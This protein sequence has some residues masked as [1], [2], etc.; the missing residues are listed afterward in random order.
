MR[1]MA[2]VIP[3]FGDA[4]QTTVL[5]EGCGFRHADVL[6][7]KEGPPTRHRLF[8]RGSSDLTARVVRSSSCTV[9][10]PE[11][12]AEMEPGMRSEAFISTAEG[13]LHRFR[14]ILGFLS[15][16]GDTE[17]RRRAALKSLG[18][19]EKMLNGKEPFTLVLEDPLGNSAILHD[20]A[21]VATLSKREAARLKTDR[22][23]LELR[24]PGPRARVSR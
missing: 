21:E 14:D 15:R 19:L 16:N 18:T 17:D 23:T 7:T 9:R 4:L 10:V 8:V 2:L 12:G 3:Y 20:Q 22:F 24:P 11:L 6:L 13:V 5:C 1:P